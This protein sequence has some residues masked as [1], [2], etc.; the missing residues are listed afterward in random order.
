M[1]TNETETVQSVERAIELLYCFTTRTPEL[2]LNA[3]V[4]RTGLNRTTVFRLLSSLMKKEL[5]NKNEAMNTY[6]LGLPFIHFAQIVTENLDLRK[7]ALPIMNELNEITKETISLNIIQGSSRI[8]IEKLEGK[9]DIRQFINLGIPYP[10][11]KGASGKL[12]LAFSKNELIEEVIEGSGL[13]K[14][15]T[16]ELKKDLLLFQ[17]QG[18]AF[19]M[20]ERI[21]GAFAISTPIL[22][23]Q[24]QLIGGLSISGLSARLDNNKQLFIKA[25]IQ[26]AEKLSAMMGYQKLGG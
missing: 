14:N 3:I 25:A 19:S 17:E 18:F 7:M 26:S 13:T 20:H 10:L 22:N 12:L 1:K 16:A 21:I 15:E 9:E 4:K 23:S 5:I 2:S 24:Q 11:Y 8:C 6:R